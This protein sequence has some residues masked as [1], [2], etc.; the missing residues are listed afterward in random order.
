M[1]S[2]ILKV[3]MWKHIRVINWQLLLFI[4]LLDSFSS[5]CMVFKIMNLIVSTLSYKIWKFGNTIVWGVVTFL[6]RALFVVPYSPH[7]SLLSSALNSSIFWSYHI[8][9]LFSYAGEIVLHFHVSIESGKN[10][11]RVRRAFVLRKLFL[12]EVKNASS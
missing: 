9:L 11:N 1:L 8:T 6:D 4:S 12:V 2:L 5:A 3:V 7:H 10:E